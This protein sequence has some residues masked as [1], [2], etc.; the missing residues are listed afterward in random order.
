MRLS[1]AK[2]LRVGQI[3]Y[4]IDQHNAN[5]TPMKAKVSG[6]V[7]TWVTKPEK[8]QVPIKHGLRD[9]SYITETNLKTFTL[10]IPATIKP[11]LSKEHVIRVFGKAGWITQPGTYRTW[12]GAS[13]KA[14]KDTSPYSVSRVVQGSDGLFR[15]QWRPA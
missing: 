1:E 3:V 14:H 10:T 9:S 13:D 15:V 7:R 6:R 12:T 2:G 11:Q 8:V 5:G 4:V